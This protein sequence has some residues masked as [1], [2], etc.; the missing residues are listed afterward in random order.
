MSLISVENIS[1]SYFGN[2]LLDGISLQINRGERLALIGE[3]GTGKTTLFRMIH[4]DESVDSGRIVVAGGCLI[5]YLTQHTEDMADL[6][7]SSL[8]SSHLAALETR[9]RELEHLMGEQPGSNDLLKEYETKTAEF[10]AAGGYTYKARMA[11]IL[12]GLGLSGETL[13]RPLTSLSGGERMR[14]AMAR[15]LVRQPDV[16]LLDEPTN[17]LDMD[18]IEWLED[19][20]SRF[21]G[22]VFFISHDRSFINRTATAVCELRDT[23]LF[24]Y[25]GNYDTYLQQKA[26]EQDYARQ[27]VQRL[28]A[29]LKRQQD[30]VQ[31]MLSH[32]NISGYHARE[33]VVVKLNEQLA[34]ARTKVD[35]GARRMNFRFIPETREGDPERIIV[36]ATEVTKA[37]DGRV[38]FSGLDLELKA[39]EKLFIVGPNGC[40]KSTLIRV[41]TGQDQDFTGDIRLSATITYA[42]MGQHVEFKDEE[43]SLYDE[44]DARSKLSQTE[45]RNRLARFGFKDTDVF[46]QIKVLS[47]GE[48]SRLYLCCLLEERP[49]LLFL[50]EPTNHLD[51]NSMEILE[52]ALADFDGA[53]LAISHDRYFIDNCASRVAGFVGPQVRFFDNFKEYRRAAVDYDRARQ[54]EARDER[55]AERERKAKD[56]GIRRAN[57]AEERRRQAKLKKEIRDHE[58]ESAALEAEIEE[59][60]ATLGPDTSPETYQRLAEASVRL[61]E[62]YEE[63]FALL[64]QQEAEAQASSEEG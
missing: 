8:E 45:I 6:E 35:S 21:G 49:D 44:L 51:V 54:D 7:Q 62:C 41:L 58:E 16:L 4:G 12:A 60:Q 55:S 22:T 47:G 31:T 5:G 10:E 14:A 42:H 3:N 1:K 48:R 11:A 2:T 29:E 23:Q 59:I 39:N 18:G 34:A 46:K 26:I 43:R 64:E 27:Q 9:L 57:R 50:D 17:H 32:R 37:F 63:Y 53:I 38:L 40:G 25:P 33:K 15:L 30:V 56:P 24:R 36:Q 52:Q 28:E 20:I 19:Y 13:D 61:E